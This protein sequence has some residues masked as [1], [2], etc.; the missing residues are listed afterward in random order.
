MLLYK[1]KL[2]GNSRVHSHILLSCSFGECRPHTV[3]RMWRTEFCVNELAYASLAEQNDWTKTKRKHTERT[4]I[5][6]QAISNLNVAKTMF[7]CV[8][9]AILS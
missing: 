8:F 5:P 9:H 1:E 6:I 7:G 2:N 3:T 4:R